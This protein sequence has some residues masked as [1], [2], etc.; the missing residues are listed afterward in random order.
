VLSCCPLRGCSTQCVADT[1]VVVHHV[2]FHLFML[3]H[4]SALINNLLDSASVR[5]VTM[6]WCNDHVPINV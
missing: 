5:D 4:L 3:Q 2:T 1:D 6:M